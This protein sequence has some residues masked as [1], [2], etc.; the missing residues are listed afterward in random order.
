MTRLGKCTMYLSIFMWPSQEYIL[1]YSCRHNSLKQGFGSV[2]FYTE[3][4][5]F[6]DEFPLKYDE[7]ELHN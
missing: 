2:T 1:L 5:D 7:K 6:E 4:T 3:D